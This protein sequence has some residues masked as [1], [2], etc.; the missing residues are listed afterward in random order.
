MNE[1]GGWTGNGRMMHDYQMHSGVDATGRLGT[2]AVDRAIDQAN[3]IDVKKVAIG[4]GLGLLAALAQGL[5]I[6]TAVYYGTKAG[7]RR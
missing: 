3:G 2:G 6:G 7:K 5:V 4:T 1:Q